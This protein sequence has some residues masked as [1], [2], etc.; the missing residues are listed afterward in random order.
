MK[1]IGM[2]SLGCPKNLVDT[3]SLLGDLS[4]NGYELTSDQAE[5]EVL[6][7]NTC[8]FLQSSVKESVET[9]LEMADYKEQ[10]ACR[11]LIVT[12]CLAERH[13]EELLREIPEIDHLLG[14]KQYPL[15]KS[16]L[17]NRDSRRNLV[18][19][20]AQ[21]LEN[22]GQ[23][24]QTTPRHMAYVKI[25][26]GCSNQC[27]FCIIPQLRGP[28]KSRT[29]D[30]ILQEVRAL[31]ENGVREI[32]LVSQD[33]TLYGYDIRLK[34]GLI[35]LLRQ[36]DRVEGVSWIR[37][38]YCYPTMVT[39]RLM[40]AVAEIDKVVPYMDI[41][42]Q[43]THDF[44]LAHMKRQEREA[45][46]RKMLDELRR[47][48]P[49]VALRTTFITGFPGETEAHFRHMHDF[50]KEYQFDHLGVF[51]YSDEEGT[52]AFNYPGRVPKEVA[53]ERRSILME[54]QRDLVRTNNT[55]R[56]G[57][58]FP[59]LVEGLDE[60]CLLT[61]RLPT[62]GP[63][64]D[65]QVILEECSAEAGSIVPVRLTGV[66]DYDFVGVPVESGESGALAGGAEME[67]EDH[68]H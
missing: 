63:E 52:T 66:L 51:V 50:L 61:G 9:I 3:E 2:V 62:Q 44:M 57:S 5:A 39:E 21:Y 58:V 31:A 16:L 27:A 4:V 11:K 55:G 42:L 60:D 32:N 18:H 33:T 38:F 41:P 28:I 48:I 45:G 26:E 22:Y 67:T 64:I 43:H 36:I 15:L 8:G 46:V 1:K 25:A 20:P 47:R 19:E 59:V 17:N 37:L 54:T 40:D 30:S 13:P 24:V 65:G 7:I 34:D 35:D 23:R 49:G 68:G 6:I 56:I 53:E 10:G 14:T 29:P 12:G